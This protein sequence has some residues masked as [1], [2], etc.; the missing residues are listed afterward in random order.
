MA[1]VTVTERRRS[2]TASTRAVRGGTAASTN[3][4]HIVPTYTDEAV[5]KVWQIIKQH[6]IT[7][8]EGHCKQKG[9]TRQWRGEA[10]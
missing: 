5:K 2:R 8:V 6:K 7:E 4:K 10:F 1:R 3:S 9:V